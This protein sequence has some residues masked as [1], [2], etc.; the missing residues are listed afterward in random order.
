MSNRAEE[1]GK[2]AFENCVKL[3]SVTM[4]AGVTKV[5]ENAFN[6]TPWYN[7]QAN[8]MRYIGKAAYKYKGEMPDNT[9]IT[10]NEG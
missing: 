6:N 10:I 2:G 3:E 9:Q 8:G 7:N 1:I 4:L 5:G